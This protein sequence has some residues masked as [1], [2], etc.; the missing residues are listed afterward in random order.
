[1][2]QRRRMRFSPSASTA[3]RLLEQREH[4]YER[5]RFERARAKA[6]AAAASHRVPDPSGGLRVV[7]RTSPG[8]GPTADQGRV[9]LA[10]LAAR[11]I[12]Q[13][14]EAGAGRNVK[15]EVAGDVTFRGDSRRVTRAIARLIATALRRARGR[16]DVL[17]RATTAHGAVVLHVHDEVSPSRGARGARSSGTR[18]RTSTQ[19][20]GGPARSGL[21]I[22]RDIVTAYGGRISVESDETHGTTFEVVLPRSPPPRLV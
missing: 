18:V 7:T 5:A 6:T 3:E 16:T 9:D 10:A 8:C 20:G 12:N 22:A 4:M 17:V 21:L 11:A 19:A 14:A 15:L 13:L 2:P 1:M